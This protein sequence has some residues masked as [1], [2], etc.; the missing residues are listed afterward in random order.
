MMEVTKITVDQARK[1]AENAVLEDIVR[2]NLIEP[3]RL[4]EDEYLEADYCWIFLRSKKIV[5]PHD[6]WFE[7]AYGAYA[8]SKK[9]GFSLITDFSD[10]P[11]KLKEYLQ[12][13][14]DYFERKGL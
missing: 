14:S 1:M 6:R 7:R 8:I 9:G 5:I 12:T 4:L 3:V 13:M 10:E 11:E 2:L